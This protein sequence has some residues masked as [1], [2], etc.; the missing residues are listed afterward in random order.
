MVGPGTPPL[1]TY[2]GDRRLTSE[3]SVLCRIDFVST[4]SLIWAMSDNI[5]FKNN[6]EF[7]SNAC[8]RNL[9]RRRQLT[10]SLLNLNLNSAKL[11][12]KLLKLPH[13]PLAPLACL[14]RPPLALRARQQGGDGGQYCLVSLNFFTDES[15]INEVLQPGLHFDRIQSCPICRTCC[16]VQ[17]DG[18]VVE[19]HNVI[20]VDIS[21]KIYHHIHK[22][23][24]TSQNGV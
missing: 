12:K 8:Q 4:P 2:P 18:E 3:L 11:K 6:C 23:D 20:L 13:L 9:G 21:T 10:E 24:K 15:N 14:I 16:L 5:A 7:C 22:S 1:A 17:E 19:V